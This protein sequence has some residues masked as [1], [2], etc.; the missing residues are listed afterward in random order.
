MYAVN[1]FG[2]GQVKLSKTQRD[3]LM[4]L[5]VLEQREVPMPFHAPKLLEFINKDRW[6]PVARQNYQAGMRTLEKN[7]L[8]VITRAQNL[9][10]Q[11]KLTDEGR[12]H[13]EVILS[14][15]TRESESDEA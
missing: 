7:G 1:D 12:M 4:L 2:V 3:A 5:V 15:R 11:V 9:S 10:L 13:G 6:T 14:D 8:L